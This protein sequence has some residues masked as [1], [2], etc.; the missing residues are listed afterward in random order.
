MFLIEIPSHPAVLAILLLI[1]L[2]PILFIG[3][4]DNEKDTKLD[5]AILNSKADKKIPIYNDPYAFD[6]LFGIKK[7]TV[8][9][10]KSIPSETKKS[11]VDIASNGRIPLSP[12]SSP[13]KNNDLYLSFHNHITNNAKIM[14]VKQYIEACVLNYD[15]T[16]TPPSIMVD[17]NQIYNTIHDIAILCETPVSLNQIFPFPISTNCNKV[18]AMTYHLDIIS[19]AEISSS[20]KECY[21]TVDLIKLNNLL[22]KIQNAYYSILLNSNT[23]R[24]FDIATHYQ[25]L[26][27]IYKIYVYTINYLYYRIMTDP[28]RNVSQDMY[29]SY[30]ITHRTYTSYLHF[31]S[32]SQHSV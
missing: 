21:S 25:Y 22:T 12:P 24:E 28:S 6:A 32:N 14:T 17:A 8:N 15:H 5:E 27:I 19:N 11:S 2:I 26:R 23:G 20:N 4:E 30:C 7:R 10:N 3:F 9:S 1:F 31:Y 29:H 16:I 13:L 18:V